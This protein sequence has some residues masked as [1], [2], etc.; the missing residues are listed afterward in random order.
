MVSDETKEKIRKANKGKKKSKE[1]I[2]KFKQTIKNRIGYKKSKTFLD[3]TRKKVNQ[4]SLDGEFIKS[5]ISITEASIL[6]GVNGSNI[7]ECC[8]GRRKTAGKFK[9]KYLKNN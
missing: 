5:Y 4:Y 3:A 6:T 2:K 8:K 7:T 1:A 9:W